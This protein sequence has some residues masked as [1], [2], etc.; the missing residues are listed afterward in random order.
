MF[1]KLNVLTLR[2]SF[3]TNSEGRLPPY[4]GSTLRGILGHCMRDFV[5]S[6]PEHRCHLCDKRDKCTYAQCFCTPGNEGGAVNPFVLYPAVKDKVEW[7][8]GDLCTFD[9]TIIGKVT[10]QASLFIDALQE[11][12]E[13]GWGAS[14]LS[15]SL[16]QVI[17]PVHKRLIFSRGKTWIRNMQPYP[18][19]TKERAASAV[20][21]H[22]DTP[23]RI[24]INR[25]LCTTLPFDVLIRSVSRRLALLHQA[26]AGDTVRWD[27]EAMLKAAGQVKTRQEHWLP[28]NFER[29][30]MRQEGNKLFLPSIQGWALYE[31]DLT[32]FTSLLQAGTRLHAGKNSTIG[33]GH[34]TLAYDR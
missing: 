4:L 28:V 23:V 11:M 18:L 14:R 8:P 12:G 5:C 13:R 20:L 9:L 27:E 21:V 33:F 10:E 6:T 19:N 25:N 3:T 32:A 26:Y 30:S 24:L 29:Y 16:E 2:A 34:Y 7:K 15:F 17:D 1:D 31:G 22:F